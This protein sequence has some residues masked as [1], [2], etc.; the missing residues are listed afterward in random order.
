MNFTLAA[1]HRYYQ[2]WHKFRKTIL[3]LGPL[4][5]DVS[6]QGKSN[7]KELLDDIS[8][9]TGRKESES[10]QH[11]A[12]SLPAQENPFTPMDKLIDKII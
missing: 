1:F 11:E 6:D 7:P 8:E 5:Q 4:L 2:R 12:L 10:A 9:Y 3:E